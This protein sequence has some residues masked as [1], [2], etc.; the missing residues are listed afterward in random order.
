LPDTLKTQ[1]FAGVP[2]VA[3]RLNSIWDDSPYY[4]SPFSG[5]PTGSFG[6]LL[7]D[8]IDGALAVLGEV[9]EAFGGFEAEAPNDRQ[10][11]IS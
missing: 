9:L 8:C 2:S 6:S 1:A 3:N 10:R 5:H 7:G 4:G 11:C